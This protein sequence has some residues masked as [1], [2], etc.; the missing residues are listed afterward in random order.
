MSQS[1]GKDSEWLSARMLLL[2]LLAVGLVAGP[3]WVEA[4]HLDDRVY[5]YD[6]AEVSVQ[7]GAIDYVP[8]GDPPGVSISEDIR[9]TGVIE[10]RACYLEQALI[11]NRTIPTARY[12][13]DNPSGPD[14]EYRFVAGPEGVYEVDVGLN[15]SQGYVVENGSIRATEEGSV[16]EDRVLYR[17]ELDLEAV[18]AGWALE[19]VSV[20]LDRVEPAVREAARSGSVRTYRPIDVPETPVKL[21]NGSTYRV[22][23]AAQHG[24]PESARTGV[25]LLRYLA[26]LAGLLLGYSLLSGLRG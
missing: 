25:L 19:R 21:E 1:A 11:G 3:L 17:V 8:E 10:T 9:C 4:L 26:P 7:D 20:D 22:Y 13:N 6:R 16:P 2:A 5:R 12:T 23:L 15:K 14:S 18:D 24:P